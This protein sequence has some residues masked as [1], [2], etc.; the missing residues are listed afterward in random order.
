M[1]VGLFGPFGVFGLISAQ[2]WV[3]IPFGNKVK[4][5]GSDAIDEQFPFTKRAL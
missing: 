3:Q 5:N 4:F 2:V 1:T